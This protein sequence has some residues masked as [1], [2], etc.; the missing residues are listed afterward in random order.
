MKHNV[1]CRITMTISAG[2]ALGLSLENLS[3]AAQGLSNAMDK[4]MPSLLALG[5]GLPK[6]E[7]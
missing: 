5:S 7:D 4:P 6:A 2:T 3:H 1:K